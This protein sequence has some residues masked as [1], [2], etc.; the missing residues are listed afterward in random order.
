MPN[1]AH[2]VA[3]LPPELR[4]RVDAELAS[5][6]RVVWLGQPVPWLF[7]REGWMSVVIGIVWT[8][9]V[10]YWMA[11]A[12]GMVEGRPRQPN[13]WEQTLLPLWGIPFF[14]IGFYL[15]TMPYWLARKARRTIYALTDRRAIVWE[16]A[17]WGKTT[18]RSF[19]PDRLLS[20]TRRARGGG[21]R[22]DLI[23]EQFLERNGS[24]TTTIRRGF[25]AIE[26]LKDADDL[27]RQTL[28]AAHANRRAGTEISHL[29]TPS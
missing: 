10:L 27:V 1:S 18:V 22:G 14:L 5:G 26:H 4:R 11:G 6:E 13:G 25:M 7:A 19:T 29:A 24:G 28:L 2:R 9:F 12:A 3:V 23:F 21:G 8:G 17:S 15:L 20:M 16:V